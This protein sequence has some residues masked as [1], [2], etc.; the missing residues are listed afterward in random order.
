MSP[1]SETGYRPSQEAMI[2]TE[3]TLSE[4]AAYLRENWRREGL[5]ATWRYLDHTGFHVKTQVDTLY[6][7]L[8]NV[9]YVSCG[10]VVGNWLQK[11]GEDMHGFVLEYLAERCVFPIR[12]RIAEVDGIARVTAPQYGN[13]LMVDTVSEKERNGIVKKTLQEDVEP[14]L[15][16]ALNGDIFVITSKDGWSGLYDTKGN[17]ILYKDSQTYL[18]QKRGSDIVGFTIRTDLSAP[19]HRLVMEGLGGNR[20]PES[21]TDEEYF[22]NVVS[23]HRRSY[24]D[25][26][27]EVVRVMQ[28]VKNSPFA[29]KDRLWNE[30]YADL[31]KRDGLWQYD[32]R[33][34][35]VINEF[36]DIVW[37]Q[38]MSRQDLEELL[39]TAI[40]RLSRKVL[41]EELRRRR[42]AGIKMSYQQSFADIEEIGDLRF[43]SYGSLLSGVEMLAGCNGGGNTNGFSS[44]YQALMLS[45]TP[46]LATNSIDKAFNHEG[47]CPHCQKSSA[48]NHYHCPDCEKEY[49]DETELLPSQRTE[50]C[51][52]GKEFGC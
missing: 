46:R 21:A 42:D 10:E 36:S 35:E 37:D 38:E 19:E 12:Y 33:T 52:C 7:D 15:L 51:D 44:V 48:D 22:S 30:I 28:D 32:T 24:H 29:Y 8:A 9:P 4:E 20:L 23:L 45:I 40:L 47:V 26:F 13:V 25:G 3:R 18:L 39:A 5:P 11:T 2:L 49:A 17:P 27:E 34:K 16:N 50:K 6:N 1:I 14:K 43:V 31:G 41:G